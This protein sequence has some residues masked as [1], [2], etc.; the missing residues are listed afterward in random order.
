[1]GISA[2]FQALYKEGLRVVQ[3]RSSLLH[4]TTAKKLLELAGQS[5]LSMKPSL[6][7]LMSGPVL[8]LALEGNSHVILRLKSILQQPVL[9]AAA[10]V[11]VGAGAGGLSTLRSMNVYNP[12]GLEDAR[13]A[14]G[15]GGGGGGGRGAQLSLGQL[16]KFRCRVLCALSTWHSGVCWW[17]SDYSLLVG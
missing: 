2:I 17:T 9:G 8:Y 12:R 3:A 7:V 10:G 13:A 14:R 15:G 11:G 16:G 4:V 6:A 5:S 1:M